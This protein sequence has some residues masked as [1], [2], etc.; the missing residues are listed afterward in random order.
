V[1]PTIVVDHILTREIR[2][3]WRY[4]MYLADTTRQKFLRWCI[5]CDE[6][7]GGYDS[8]LAAK[9]AAHAVRRSLGLCMTPAEGEHD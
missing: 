3:R 4:S 2:G 5:T 1:P 7:Q 9:R 6:M 8:E